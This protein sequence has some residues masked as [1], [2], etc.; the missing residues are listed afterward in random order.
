[1]IKA[2]IFDF[3]GV[4]ID[5]NKIANDIFMKVIKKN[6]GLEK[7]LEE[8]TRMVGLRFEQRIEL[9]AEKFNLTITQETINK[10]MSDG[11]EEYR[12]I[13]IEQVLMFP[14]AKELIQTLYENNFKIALGTNGSRIPVIQKLEHLDL[15][16][17]FSSIVTANDVG[18][19]KPDSEMFLKNAK[20]LGVKPTECVVIE[21]SITGIS[22]AK[23]AGIKVIAVQ[24]TLSK[25]QLQE[26]N[27]VV[28]SIKDINLELIKK[29]GES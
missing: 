20:E 1:M 22:A 29:L 28:E 12:E 6:L 9:I 8:F 11:I 2:V 7:N 3:D 14:G 4:I 10:I 13:H 26:A 27:L 16:K 17:Y 5:S 24:T 25:E 15:K 18:K 23:L 19:L 21:D